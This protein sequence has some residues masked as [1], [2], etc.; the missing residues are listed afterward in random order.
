[1]LRSGKTSLMSVVFVVVW[2][3]SLFSTLPVYHHAITA[4]I[5]GDGRLG[6]GIYT[7]CLA[8]WFSYRYSIPLYFTP[9]QHSD[10]FSFETV[11]KFIDTNIESR[12]AQVID[13]LSEDQ[14]IDQLKK[15]QVPTLF[16][17]G[18]G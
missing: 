15:A 13:I 4:K 7:Y 3:S 5:I 6:D 9:F 11:E 10:A 14:L 17:L 1:M 8:K 12:F 18:F 2:V 16:T